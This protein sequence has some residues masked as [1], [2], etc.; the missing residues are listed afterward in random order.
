MITISQHAITATYQ[1]VQPII[2]K[3]IHYFRQRF[4]HHEATID[5][6]LSLANEIFMEVYH[7]FD[8]RRGCPFYRRVSFRI[9]YR[10]LREFVQREAQQKHRRAGKTIVMDMT[11]DKCSKPISQFILSEFTEDL[12]E[13]ARAIVKLIID[14]PDDLKHALRMDSP[15]PTGTAVKSGLRQYLIG[16][17]WTA[18]KIKKTFSEI[19]TAIKA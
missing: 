13:D 6:L 15:D 19:S 14:T 16:L 8:P 3:Q 10:F 11:E 4:S 1:E 12:T 2:W 7:D 18:K 5:N 17:G 9:W